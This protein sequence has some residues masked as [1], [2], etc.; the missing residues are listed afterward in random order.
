VA[1]GVGGILANKG[2]VGISVLVGDTSLL[3]VNAHF[4]G[5][6]NVKNGCIAKLCIYCLLQHIRNE[7]IYVIKIM[8][9]L[10]KN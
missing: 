1:T 2:A 3:F 8:N 5:K 9:A 6:Y 4:A 10:K 7:Y